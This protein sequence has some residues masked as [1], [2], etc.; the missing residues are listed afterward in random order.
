M[1][2]K[3]S[4]TRLPEE[5]EIYI[6]N[7][8][9]NFNYLDETE[10]NLYTYNTG[11]LY[12]SK[13]T[14]EN[15][16]NAKQIKE[17]LIKIENIK[18]IHKKSEKEEESVEKDVV[19]YNYP[20]IYNMILKFLKEKGTETKKNIVYHISEI[21][22]TDPESEDFD[23]TILQIDKTLKQMVENKELIRNYDKYSII[24]GAAK[25]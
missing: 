3:K 20:N 5:D 8:F 7:I 9:N 6:D 14:T 25:P 15:S 10:K 13:K 11:I 2:T 1:F 21:Y 24:K 19:Y 16:S 17:S 22:E 18:D 23:L 4:A 12:S